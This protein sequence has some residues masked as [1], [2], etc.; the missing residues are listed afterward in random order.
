[1]TEGRV[2]GDDKPGNDQ[3]NPIT[4]PANGLSLTS[5][6][7]V[8]PKRKRSISHRASIPPDEGRLRAGSGAW[9][10]RR[11]LDFVLEIVQLILEFGDPRWPVLNGLVFGYRFGKGI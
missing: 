8:T 3:E 7:N 1:M 2:R 4:V 11:G 9:C 10:P 6:H 5:H